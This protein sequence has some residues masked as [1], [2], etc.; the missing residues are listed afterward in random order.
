MPPDAISVV[1][2]TREQLYERVWSISMHKLAPSFGLSDVGLKK[3]CYRHKVPT[4]PRGYWAKL[5]AGH[6]VKKFPLPVV[7]DPVLQVI[8]VGY[9]PDP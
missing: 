8:R 1:S 2:L 5:R 7:S 4:P 6:A 9:D 3:L